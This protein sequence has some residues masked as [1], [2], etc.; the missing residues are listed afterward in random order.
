M[1]KSRSESK[2]CDALIRCMERLQEVLNVSSLNVMKSR[3]EMI[4]RQQGLG[5]HITDATCYLTADLF[6]LEAVLLP[7]GGV[8]AVKVAPHGG[9]PVSSKSFLEL[10][11]S[12]DFA[13][14]SKKLGDVFNQYNIPG[15]NELK[16][17]LFEALQILGKDLE[18]MSKL[19]RI[20]TNSNSETDQINN[21]IVG[22]VIAGKED[23]P[24]TVRFYSSPSD[25]P[26]AP[27]SDSEPLLHTAQLTIGLSDVPRRLQMASSISQPPQPDAQGHPMFKSKNE[28]PCDLV[29][30]CFLLKLQPAIPMMPSFVNRLYQITDVTIPEVDLQWAPLPSLLMRGLNSHRDTSDDQDV[31]STVSL[32]DRGAHTYVF[33]RAAWEVPTHR[34]TLVDKIPFTHLSHVPALLELLRHQCA[35]NSLLRSTIISHCSS[36]DLPCDLYFE[37]LPETDTSFTVTFRRPDTDS[38]AVLVVDAPDS[39]QVTCRLFGAGLSD[40][41]L[42]EYISSATKRY[43]SLPVTLRTLYSKLE[44]ITSAPVSPSRPAATKAVND[45][46]SPSDVSAMDTN[47]ALTT[48]S[49]SAAVSEDSFSV[50]S[51]A[52]YAAMP[53]AQS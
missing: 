7:C 40:P 29:A 53:V 37:V 44:E 31:I 3:L 28:V 30:A 38:L 2:P 26:K 23:C 14:F 43:Q 24:L 10:L 33:P 25:G 18:Q 41:S 17:K 35:I 8:E 13:T 51:S 11:R 21:S 12:K 42:E 4:A 47:G 45:H 32:P 39:R 16:L 36:P 1:D 49:Q 48:F 46:L 5:F 50:S 27:V 22:S 20:S 15:D 6:Y 9:A 52:C 34:G 19:P